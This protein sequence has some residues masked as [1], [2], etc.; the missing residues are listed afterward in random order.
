MSTLELTVASGDLLPVVQFRARERVSTPFVV[1]IW[2]MTEEA[3]IDLAAIVGRSAQFRAASGVVFAQHAERLYGGVIC[4]AE[5]VHAVAERAGQVGV[6][7]YLFCLVPRLWLLTRRRDN[8]IFQQLSIPDIVSEVL[9]PFGVKHVWRI[10]KAK[11]PTLD[12]KA[13]YAESDYSFV[14]R[15]LEEAGITYTFEADKSGVSVLVLSDRPEGAA[16]RAGA[17]LPYVD[18]PS[19]AS[20]KEYVTRVGYFREVRPG[21]VTLRDYDPRRPPLPLFAEAPRVMEESQY[22]QYYYDAGAFLVETGKPEGT[23]TGD[24]RGFARHDLAYGLGLAERMLH[25]E[26]TGG[27]SIEFDT[28]AFDLA[29]GTVFSI[30]NH[31]QQALPPSRRFW[32]LESIFEGKVEAEWS[33]SAVTAPADHPYHPPRTTPKPKVYGVQVARVVGP[34]GQEIHT[35]EYGRVRVELPWDRKGYSDNR[36]SCWVRVS[37]GWGGMGYGMITIPRIGQEVILSFLEGDPDQPVIGGRVYNAVEQVP[38][39][40]PEHKTRSTWK[41]DSSPGSSGFNE[42]MMEDLASKELVWE[43]AQKDR[44][45]EVKNDEIATI[46]HDRQKL[47]KKDETDHTDG[48]RLRWVGKNADEVIKQDRRERIEHHSHV[49]VVGHDRQKVRGDSS[50]TVV[51]DHHEKVTGRYALKAKKAVHGV[52]EDIIGQGEDVTLKGPGGFLRIDQ[53]GV[54][55]SGT[56]VKINAGGKPGQGPGS[57]PKA[58]DQPVLG[59]I[60]A[61][62]ELRWGKPKVPVGEQVQ[63]SFRVRHFQGGET[64]LVKVFEMSTDGGKRQVDELSVPVKVTDGDVTVSWART[65]EQA[66]GDLQDDEAEGDLGPLEY[67]FEVEA[68]S[69]RAEEP[70]GPLWLT[71]TVIVNVLGNAS[72]VTLTTSEGKKTKPVSGGKAVFENVLVGKI[73]VFVKEPQS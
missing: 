73:K 72:K 29:P 71:N 47:V 7:T 34:K 22:E 33:L 24:D 46:V 1:D 45:R 20:E 61:I 57:K 21:A 36:S 48:Q 35:D 40:L 54:T 42:I 19:E 55:I 6:S 69:I 4:R 23:P 37:Q 30:A 3:S 49:E 50:L 31:P 41:S 28:N 63:A 18:N 11:Y 17:P 13:Q 67:R 52:A 27:H 58:P 44:T 25:G 56:I 43:K 65:P 64:A 62:V 51:E 39:R 9:S 66:E 59:K 12:Y 68:G 32:V 16:P 26:R 14:A 38:Y 10:D 5:Q 53:A 15:L 60:P 2:A 8:R 70:S